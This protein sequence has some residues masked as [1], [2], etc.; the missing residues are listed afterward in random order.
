[1]DYTM[2]QIAELQ[3]VDNLPPLEMLRTLFDVTD[4]PTKAA[5]CELEFQ[6]MHLPEAYNLTT[7][8]FADKMPPILVLLKFSILR[9]Y[10]YAAL[11]F[12]QLL[13][14]EMKKALEIDALELW[15]SLETEPVVSPSTFICPENLSTE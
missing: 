9:G 14:K 10:K 4:P 15:E 1:M 5:L 3:A 2:G 6:E 11:H 7:T 12:L 13:Q 8:P